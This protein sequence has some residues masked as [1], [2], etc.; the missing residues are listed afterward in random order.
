MED[1]EKIRKNL[2][3]KSTKNGRREREK[4]GV[5]T[6]QRRKSKRKDGV[7]IVVG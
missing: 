4:E 3:G 6:K 7:K 2:N 1:K 5:E